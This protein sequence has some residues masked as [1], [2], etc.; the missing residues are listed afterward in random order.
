MC[1]YCETPQRALGTEDW[2]K[3]TTVAVK[4]SEAL[5]TKFLRLVSGR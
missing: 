4:S 1:A 3:V 2:D 5:G